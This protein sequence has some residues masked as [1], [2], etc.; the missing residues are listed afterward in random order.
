VAFNFINCK[1]QI[2]KAPKISRNAFFYQLENVD[3]TTA[4]NKQ[5]PTHAVD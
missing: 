5:T 1:A 4:T 3:K 2:K